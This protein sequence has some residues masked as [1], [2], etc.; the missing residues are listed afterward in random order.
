MK[1]L[2][3]TVENLLHSWFSRTR[4]AG[5]EEG[6][7]G[8]ASRLGARPWV[9]TGRSVP[10][11]AAPPFDPLRVELTRDHYLKLVGAAGTAIVCT[12]GKLWITEEGESEDFLVT[13]GRC[14]TIRGRGVTVISALMPSHFSVHASPT[15]RA[16]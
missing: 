14:L 13:P 6:R 12:A 11:Q 7:L 15:A 4:F 8:L 3:D 5:I 10:R 2:T 9:P 1:K 16:L